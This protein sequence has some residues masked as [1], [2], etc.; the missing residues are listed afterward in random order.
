MDEAGASKSATPR[1]SFVPAVYGIADSQTLGVERLVE[2]VA[3]MAAAGIGWIQV[4]VKELSDDEWLECVRECAALRQ[5]ENFALWVNDRPDLAALV[6]ADGVHLGQSDLPPS[7]ARAVV[8]DDCRIGVSCHDLEQLRTASMN[9]DVDVIALGPVFPTRS[10][11]KADPAL[12]LDA[13][14]VAR[15]L[16]RKPLIA[17]GG[18]DARRLP[19]VLA[20]GADGAAIIGALCRGSIETNCRQLLEGAERPA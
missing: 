3:T 17:I 2:A 15:D 20:R 18:I 8:G 12:G 13:I 7:A 9:P 10:K 16:T 4:R 11:K 1:V 5:R 19:E 14:A 6:A